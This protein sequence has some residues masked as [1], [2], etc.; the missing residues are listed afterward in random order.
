MEIEITDDEALPITIIAD[1]QFS[2]SL[3][4]LLKKLEIWL[5]FQALKANW[6]A[7]EDFILSFHFTFIK[8][9]EAKS[10][11]FQENNYT[12]EPGYAFSYNE[13]NLT[14][15]AFIAIADLAKNPKNIEQKIKE[16]LTKVAN[17]IAKKH[18]FFLLP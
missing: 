11:Y 5:N 12:I 3:K 10:Q 1:N 7:D 4:P 8:T 15:T 17:I 18:D 9:L 2:S 14:T 16:R 6:F 13:N